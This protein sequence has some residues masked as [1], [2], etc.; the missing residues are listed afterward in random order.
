[1]FR[2][3]RGP[4]QFAQALLLTVSLVIVPLGPRPVFAQGEWPQ[5]A[6][7]PGTG[8]PIP[9]P[10]EWRG[11]V[12]PDETVGEPVEPAADPQSRRSR[13]QQSG[14][15]DGQMGAQSSP[16]RMRAGGSDWPRERRETD[17]PSPE[18]LRYLASYPDTPPLPSPKAV[19]GEVAEPVMQNV[20]QAEP[21]PVA[22]SLDPETLAQINSLLL[23]TFS[24]TAPTDPG[25]RAMRGLLARGQ[26]AGVLIRAENARSG[27]Q[28]AELVKF[29]QQADRGREVIIAASETG[30]EASHF[31]FTRAGAPWPSQRDLGTRNDPHF[32]HLTYRHVAASLRRYGVTLNI[33]PVLSVT[34]EPAQPSFGG[35]ARHVAAFARTF[36]LGHADAGLISIPLLPLAEAQGEAADAALLLAGGEPIMLATMGS[37]S[38]GAAQ[39]QIPARLAAQVSLRFCGTF[40]AGGGE[41]IAAA[42]AAGCDFLMVEG[43]ADASAKHAAVVALIADALREGRL[44]TERLADAARRARVFSGKTEKAS[45]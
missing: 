17:T 20:V 7:P 29:L 42:L 4:A 43:G 35:G 32:A 33:G 38:G 40:G 3:R 12:Q 30:G 14:R 25:V 6:P 36:S 39:W 2:K 44:G 37:A 26:A 24:G 18:H 27:S 16:S 10:G 15:T 23:F 13:R 45:R 11:G 8:A 1:M 21:E 41:D 34:D 28:F 22:R 9:P 19:A 5:T 31:T